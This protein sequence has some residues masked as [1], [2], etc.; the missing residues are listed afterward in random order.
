MNTTKGYALIVLAL[1]AFVIVAAVPHAVHASSCGDGIVQSPDG[2]GIHESCDEGAANGVAPSLSCGHSATYCSSSCSVETE[3]APACPKPTVCGDGI[4][5]SPDSSGIHEQCDNGGSNTN[6]MSAPYGET[7]SYCTSSCTIATAKGGYCGDGICQPGYET[8]FTCPSDCGSGAIATQNLSIDLW[9]NPTKTAAPGDVFYSC[10]AAYGTKPYAFTLSFGDGS[11]PVSGSS[12]PSGH[13]TYANPGNYTMRCSVRDAAGASKSATERIEITKPN[14]VPT[15]ISFPITP[16]SG[17]SPFTVSYS[18]AAQGGDRPISYRIAFGD[19]STTSQASGS[20]TYALP[21]GVLNKTY[22]ASCI[23]TDANGDQIGATNSTVVSAPVNKI[24]TA[25]LSVT[26]SSGTAPLA[27][28]YSCTASGGDEPYTFSL[29]FGD[30]GSSGWPSG[31]HTYASAGSYT[32]TCVVYDSNG[33][34]AQASQAVTVTAPP[35]PPAPT[36]SLTVTP[37]RGPAP[38]SV[39]YSCSASGASPFSYVV[40]FGDGSKSTA[41]SGT[42]V[43][44]SAG[45]Y[46][47]RCVATDINGRTG[48]AS[49]SVA[50]SKPV[51]LKPSVSLAAHP[52]SGTAPLD[53]NYSCSVT[54]GDRPLKSV[55]VDFGDGSESSSLTG[56]HRYENAGSYAMTCTAV[57]ANGDAASA[58][59]RIAVSTAP[60]NKIPTARLNVTPTSGTA[61]LTVTYSCF[62]ADGDAPYTIA[63][64]FGDG[65]SQAP[66]SGQEVSGQHTYAAVGSYSVTCTVRDSNGDIAHDAANVTVSAP[67]NKIPTADLTVSPDHG[68]APLTVTYTCSAAKGDAPYTIAVDFGDGTSQAALPG[69]QVSG[70]HTYT[71]AH[72]KSMTYTATCTVTDANGDVAHDAAKVRVTASQPALTCEQ[73]KAAGLLYATHVGGNV[74]IVD[75]ANSSYAVGV[76]SFEMYDRTLANQV[77]HDAANGTVSAHGS[78]DLAVKVPM[79]AYQL[80][81]YCDPA[82][83]AASGPY[84][85]ESLIAGWVDTSAGFC[86]ETPKVSLSIVPTSG[87]APLDVN[88]SCS[89]SGGN[90]PVSAHVEF[91]DGT[92]SSSLSGQHTYANPGSYL[93]RCVATDANGDS[94][95]SEVRVTAYKDVPA[96]AKLTLDPTSGFAPLNVSYA[97]DATWGNEPF[98]Y[99]LDLGDGSVVTRT[100]GYGDAP[101][102]SHTYASAGTYPVTC[103][104]TDANGDSDTAHGSV[105]VKP[106][107]NLTS[108]DFS[109]VPAQGREPLTTNVS[110]HAYPGAGQVSYTVDLGDGRTRTAT[111]SYSELVTYAHYGVYDLACTATDELGHT[112]TAHASVTVLPDSAVSISPHAPYDRDNLSCSVVKYPSGSF[113]YVWT[114][115]GVVISRQ[116]GVATGTLSSSSTSANDTIGCSASLP[117]SSL[118]IGNDSVFVRKNPYTGP[119]N[120]SFDVSPNAGE[121]PLPVSWTCAAQG[122]VAPVSYEVALAGSNAS[123]SGQTGSATLAAGAYTFTCTAT[124][125]NGDTASASDSVTV[126]APNYSSRWSIAAHPLSGLAPLAVTFMANTSRIPIVGPV[127]WDFGDAITDA[128][129]PVLHVY[130]APGVFTATARAT[131]A[132]GTVLTKR[133]AITVTPKSQPP[134]PRVDYGRVR[135]THSF[136]DI[137]DGVLYGTVTVQNDAGTTISGLTAVVYL[138][139]LDVYS[140]QKMAPIENG[141]SETV[142]FFVPISGQTFDTYAKYAVYNDHVHL[143]DGTVVLG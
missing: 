110:C 75:D 32:A 136:G 123:W 108:I 88:Y 28:K 133:V 29:S 61:P 3:K 18:C 22:V 100:G 105:L 38:L 16:G 8:A 135:I 125:A 94:A 92:S 27:T 69:Q 107:G 81:V 73:A 43:Y 95:K 72:D 117:G 77:F 5:Q 44:R 119:A 59:Q 124:D 13:H 21:S 79:C 96:R 103:T 85:N 37:D 62:A 55:I 137:V 30:G 76:A 11:S 51:N 139:E 48:S 71:L 10:A 104:V 26:P 74:H 84:Y 129:S 65:T 121:A 83:N 114:R 80:D 132:N 15:S 24:P 7:V 82:E 106:R 57:D 1:F 35:L 47:A 9:A 134:A 122:G 52:T 54:G 118:P 91:G 4:V 19:G 131:L 2:S 33:D 90:E 116:S 39:S 41:A 112:R 89:V 25:H 53:V 111:G 46:T 87:F 63:V 86:G 99:R 34:R 143:S 20:H 93:A 102:G 12:G 126:S 127:R 128:G 68:V 101:H 56:S 6:L 50:V 66:I 14:L 70:Q 109:A 138:P 130:P 113:D 36:V 67:V 142:R 115:N 40:D 140:S 120:V 23:A 17:T 141:H 49:H 98:T 42:H 60:V 97:C 45:D 31:S 58:G 78:L 64:D